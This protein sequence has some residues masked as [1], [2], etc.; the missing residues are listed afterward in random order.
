MKP[1]R[2][3]YDALIESLA[4]GDE[5]DWAAYSA[6][7]ATEDDR[8]R[9]GNLRLVARM[10]ELHRTL[11]L[12]AGDDPLEPAPAVSE[13]FETWGHLQ[14]RGRIAGGAFGDVYA[15]RDPQLDRDVALKILRPSARRGIDRLLEEGR[16]LARVRHPNVVTVYGADVRDGRAGLWME[17]IDGQTLESWLDLHGPM[18]PGEV[19]AV[20]ADLCGALAAVHAAGL[21]HG[22]VKAQN[23]MRAEG[24]RI[25]LMDF[26]AGHVQGA[27][28][29]AGTPLYLAPEV[30]DRQPA[31]PR[32]DIYSL[33]VL[34]FHLLT[35]QYPCRADGLENLK[36]AHAEGKRV[37]LRDL[38][39]DLPASLVDPVERALDPE[40]RRRFATPGELEQALTDRTDP[41]PAPKRLSRA[42]AAAAVATAALLLAAFGFSWMWRS[43]V[44][45]GGSVA[46]LP[47]F[48]GS[49]EPDHL[50]AGLT[51]DVVR[52]LQ[53]F[54]ITVK[55]GGPPVI[56]AGAGAVS[57]ERLDA[58]AFIRG[59]AQRLGDRTVL[60]IAVVRPG[61][62]EWWSR[63]YD[64]PAEGLPA[65]ARNVAAEVAAAIGA[66]PRAGVP[67]PSHQT[68]YRAYEAYLRGRAEAE[69]RDSA[70]MLRSLEFYKQAAALDP[71][72]AEPYA[73]MADTYSAMGVHA[74]GAMA[75]LESRRLAKVFGLKALELNPDLAEAHT[76]LAFAAFVHDW[77]WQEAQQRFERALSINPQYALA[78]H[79]YAELLNTLDRVDEAMTQIHLAQQLDPLSILIHRDIAW[80]YFCQG[81][82]AEAVAQLNETLKMDPGFPAALTLLA[83]SLAGLGR[84]DEALPTLERARPGLSHVA[85]LGF[86]GAIEAAA[87][88]R[89]E[90]ERTLAEMRGLSEREY[91]PPYAL[92]LIHTALGQTEQA[93]TQ[94][95][96]GY[97]RQDT[98][99]VSVAIDPRF[100]PLHDQPRFNA[101]LETMRLTRRP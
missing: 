2:L 81:R 100:K 57:A 86:R 35:G 64:V 19:T 11:S 79:W 84:F 74:F 101:L 12:E 77:D 44:G 54:D 27:T 92:A 88:R 39:P 26:G 33:G 87:G 38:R 9:F 37:F 93:L 18:G 60:R 20:A 41:R 66:R 31:T 6:G 50:M 25:V 63:E 49:G 82:Y 71:N 94:L 23:V 15:A 85:Y 69:K 59:D 96:E 17:R 24:G 55:K 40:P 51:R 32:S 30:L 73:G 29:A 46:V 48:D 76:S 5:I 4:D 1:E 45:P 75:P 34:L 78:H 98:T 97:R 14:I 61:G 68:N 21:V 56:Q 91:V 80:H 90:A 22:D 62:W 3:D 47:F 58:D 99:M 53:R 8:R 95:E 83:R 43:P 65:L 72:Y 28:S 36:A 10:A 89:R 13:P 16:T 70:A 52:E 67:G 42:V 7:A